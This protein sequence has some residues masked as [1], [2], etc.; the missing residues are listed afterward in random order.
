MS[1]ILNEEAGKIY[2]FRITVTNYDLKVRGMPY[3]V[4]AIP[5]N[6][7]LF[8]LSTEIID[9]FNFCYDHCFGFF[10]FSKRYFWSDERYEL[11]TDLEDYGYLEP[12]PSFF[13][14][15][16]PKKERS[17]SLVKTFIP[18]VFDTPKKKMIFLFDYGDQWNFIVQLQKVEPIDFEGKY[19]CICKSVGK[20]PE[21]YPDFDDQ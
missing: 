12:Q 7:T 9:S 20:S 5:G 16:D 6:F 14:G 18:E 8:N 3:R 13:G 4:M 17:G 2:Y 15:L 19:P 21:Q 11:F 1:I 10:G